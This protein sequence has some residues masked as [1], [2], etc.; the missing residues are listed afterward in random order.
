MSI[1]ITHHVDIENLLQP[2]LLTFIRNAELNLTVIIYRLHVMELV[3]SV[4]GVGR[5]KG[6]LR[7]CRTGRPPIAGPHSSLLLL[8]LLLLP[9]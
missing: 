2:P 9:P 3:A 6:T 1:L 5:G 4:V 8:L 7:M